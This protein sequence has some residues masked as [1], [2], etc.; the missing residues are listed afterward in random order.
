M[1]EVNLTTISNVTEMVLQLQGVEH[2]ASFR[3]TT[4][5]CDTQ[6]KDKY[7]VVLHEAYTQEKLAAN[8]L[9]S[10][11][12]DVNEA[13]LNIRSSFGNDTEVGV[14]MGTAIVSDHGNEAAHVE[15]CECPGHF[16]DLS[17]QNCNTGNPLFAKSC[18]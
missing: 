5:Q 13:A 2:N 1:F 17:C 11:L 9:Q 6:Q 15:R 8:Q 7:C 16:K 12:A 18:S 14:A 4:T 3:L 10:I